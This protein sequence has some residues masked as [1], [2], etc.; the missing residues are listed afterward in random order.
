MGSKFDRDNLISTFEESFAKEF[1]ALQDYIADLKR[2]IDETSKSLDN[3]YNETLDIEYK[4]ALKQAQFYHEVQQKLE[5]DPQ[6]LARVA[7]LIARNS[8]DIKKVLRGDTD[9]ATNSIKPFVDFRADTA[10]SQNGAGNAI[11][12]FCMYNMEAMKEQDNVSKLSRAFGTPVVASMMDDLVSS[13]PSDCIATDSIRVDKAVDALG[14]NQRS[15]LMSYFKK[16]GRYN[17]NFT[18]IIKALYTGASLEDYF[19]VEESMGD[20]SPYTYDNVQIDLHRV[21]S[22]FDTLMKLADSY[23]K[24]G[25]SDSNQDGIT[26]IQETVNNEELDKHVLHNQ[27]FMTLY[28]D[29][30]NVYNRVSK[31]QPFTKDDKRVMDRVVRDVLTNPMNV[32][33]NNN[34]KLVTAYVYHKA[35][36]DKN[37]NALYQSNQSMGFGS[38]EKVDPKIKGNNLKPALRRVN[39]NYDTKTAA[40]DLSY[41]I[42]HSKDF[43]KGTLPDAEAVVGN[44]DTAFADYASYLDS[45]NGEGD[46]VRGLVEQIMNARPSGVKKPNAEQIGKAQAKKRDDVLTNMSVFCNYGIDDNTNA[47][48]AKSITDLRINELIVLLYRTAYE[49]WQDIPLPTPDHIAGA[50]NANRDLLYSEILNRRDSIISQELFERFRNLDAELQ[51][52]DPAKHSSIYGHNNSNNDTAAS[53]GDIMQE[54]SKFSENRTGDIVDMFIS[55]KPL[56]DSV[57]G[58][59]FTSTF[60]KPNSG[61]VSLSCKCNV[62]KKN[63]NGTTHIASNTKLNP[64]EIIVFKENGVT[65][66]ASVINGIGKPEDKQYLITSV[67]GIEDNDTDVEFVRFQLKN[68]FIGG[69]IQAK[70]DDVF[71][72]LKDWSDDYTA[73]SVPDEVMFKALCLKYLFAGSGCAKVIKTLVSYYVWKLSGYDYELTPRGDISG[74]NPTGHYIGEFR[75]AIADDLRKFKETDPR[76]YNKIYDFATK[77][78]I[79]D[80]I[81]ANTNLSSNEDTKNETKENENLINATALD[82]NVKKMFKD[83]AD[84]IVEEYGFV[85]QSLIDDTLPKVM[86]SKEGADKLIDLA[87]NAYKGVVDSIIRKSNMT[88]AE[89]LIDAYKRDCASS[90][91]S[92]SVDGAIQYV[93]D[94]FSGPKSTDDNGNNI[95]DELAAYLKQNCSPDIDWKLTKPN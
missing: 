68:K 2:R 79:M 24:I 83:F 10:R 51:L 1:K 40:L 95:S 7:D 44:L 25:T 36:I 48:E 60:G 90:G 46:H 35:G 13:V 58:E 81:R 64:G 14:D 61:G 66:P 27:Y 57:L 42:T 73:E 71:A 74:D 37:Q 47:A 92:P 5:S 76:I 69:N 91:V 88:I 39:P 41:R 87:H 30:I 9:E 59:L 20:T 56:D 34:V 72:Q 82:T 43:V 75:R 23:N 38:G 17:P 33:I 22:F 45:I 26:H 85:S 49:I 94:N 80:S 53:A 50:V 6:L 62:V 21:K 15:L 54:R 63:T 29:F 55:E 19:A 65:K 18:N 86:S 70:A 32:L 12:D 77:T 3:S 31:G 78:G 16:A 28:S 11:I 52:A 67:P 8:D 4:E 89:P 93:K 84:Y